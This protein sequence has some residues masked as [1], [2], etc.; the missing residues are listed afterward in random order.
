M[1]Q[2]ITKQSILDA[3]KRATH[4]AWDGCHKIYLLDDSSYE[5]MKASGYGE[6][7]SDSLLE[8][9]PE[10]PEKALTEVWDNYEA[11][12]SLRFIYLITSSPTDIELERF[13]VFPNGLTY[14]DVV[15]MGVDLEW[16]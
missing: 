11:S 12:C 4:I 3:L 2:E 9:L 1:T 16:D 5:S 6:P 14:V 15:P 7:G 8:P 10:D 13:G